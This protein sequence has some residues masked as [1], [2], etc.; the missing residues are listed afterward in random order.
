MLNEYGTNYT[1]DVREARKLGWNKFS[2]SWSVGKK[3]GTYFLYCRSRADALELINFWSGS[4][5][6][7]ILTTPG[8]G[9]YLS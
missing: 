7:Y 3:S 4:V 6:H 2:Y 1:R 5:W 9:E 8:N